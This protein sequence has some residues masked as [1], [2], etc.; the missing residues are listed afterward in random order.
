MLVHNVADYETLVDNKRVYLTKIE[1]RLLTNIIDGKL[2]TRESLLANV[3]G[4]DP[5][6][7]TRTVDMHM[8]RL[9]RKLG[10][11]GS[12]IKSLHGLGYRLEK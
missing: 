10:V 9:K 6:N 2:H 7:K 3:W 12:R 5:T 8:S 4:A 11:E 1:F